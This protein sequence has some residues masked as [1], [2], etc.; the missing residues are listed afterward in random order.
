MFVAAVGFASA[1]GAADAGPVGGAVAGGGEPGCLDEGLGQEGGGA[2]AGVPVGGQPAGDGGEQP[3]G[4]VRD[5]HVGADEEPGV[6]ADQV[7][8]G[9]AGGGVP[10]DPG[11][12]RGAFPGAGGEGERGD[13]AGRGGGGE[14]ADL[15]AGQRGVA[16]VVVVA[17][18]LVPL[19]GGGAA[20]DDA[21]GDRA[22]IGQGG[23][24]AGR[25]RQ[26]ELAAAVHVAGV[27]A[28]AVAV[29]RGRQGD[30][31][32]GG[33]LVQGDAGGHVLAPPAGGV[34]AEGVADGAGDLGAA[35]QRRR[36]LDDDRQ[37]GGGE[38]PAAVAGRA[39]VARGA[40]GGHGGLPVVFPGVAGSPGRV[41]FHGSR[42]ARWGAC[43]RSRRRL[44]GRCS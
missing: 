30:Q 33:H 26:G 29:T 35:G 2:V 19:A 12:A 5:R 20:V 7:Q 22:E 9:A 27:A 40:G 11:V 14:V 44:P 24:G 41:M 37:L 23:G 21:D 32:V 18:Q 4:E 3:G 8:V 16:E 43:R 34:P 1:L 31:G 13:L 15:G 6:A 10:A 42:A 38:V 28:V 25:Q 39:G 17:D 36:E